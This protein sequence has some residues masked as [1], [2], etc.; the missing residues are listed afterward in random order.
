VTPIVLQIAR[1]HAHHVGTLGADWAQV[2]LALSD[3]PAFSA[4]PGDPLAAEICVAAA[5]PTLQDVLLETLNAADPASAG[6][7]ARLVSVVLY[8]ALPTPSPAL[9]AALER[10]LAGDGAWYLAWTLDGLGALTEQHLTAALRIPD[11]T[12]WLRPALQMRAPNSGDAVTAE[13]CAA[14]RPTLA[15]EPA[16]L[17]NVLRLLGV[18]ILPST[19]IFLRDAVQHGALEAGASEVRVPAGPGR[20]PEARAR[21]WLADLTADVAHPAAVLLRALYT[22]DAPPPSLPVLAAA[23]W[24]RH[25]APDEPIDDVL[26]RSGGLDARRLA[27]ARAAIGPEDR[28]RVESAVSSRYD[29]GPAVLALPL[30]SPPL[31]GSPEVARTLIR[32]AGGPVGEIAVWQT[33]AAI[34]AR[35][36]P[37]ALVALLEDEET[38]LMGARLARWCPHAAVTQRIQALGIQAQEPKDAPLRR[39]SAWALASSG[40]PMAV[41]PLVQLMKAHPEDVPSGAI[42]LAAEVLRA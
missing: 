38:R 17:Q 34:A 30:V 2:Q 19:G 22:T 26:F 39:A 9:I 23:S 4:L 11:A 6:L 5:P 16:R 41:V 31:D 8:G 12:G 21:A 25:F 24:V 32:R 7:A 27:A 10:G 29:A 3:P 28:A 18:P 13:I 15:P 33:A 35:R 40:D 42:G 14:L 36:E 20:T 1:R 37:A